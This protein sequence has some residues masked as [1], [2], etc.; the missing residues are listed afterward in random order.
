MTQHPIENRPINSE[1]MSRGTGY[2]TDFIKYIDTLENGFRSEDLDPSMQKMALESTQQFT[3]RSMEEWR[4]Y[5][6]GVIYELKK[7][8]KSTGT[9]SGIDFEEKVDEWNSSY[10]GFQRYLQLIITEGAKIDK[11]EVVMND[12]QIL[13]K[14]QGLG[15]TDNIIHWC[16]QVQIG[17]KKSE[18][19]DI[20][21]IESFNRFREKQNGKITMQHKAVEV[22][23]VSKSYGDKKAVDGVSFTVKRGSIFGLLGPNGAGK[24]T[25]IECIE[26]M[27]E[28]ES[29]KVVLLENERGGKKEIYQKLGIQFQKTGLFENLTIKETLILYA[30]F[31]DKTLSIDEVL[32]L[33]NL[34]K[35]QNKFIKHLSGGMYQSVSLAIAL[36]ND[37]DILFLDEPTTGLDPHVKRDLWGI[38]LK[39]KEQK[40]TVI[41]TTHYMEEAEELCDEI[42]IMD[43]GRVVD[44]GNPAELIKRHLGS[45]TIECRI[46]SEVDMN[47]IENLPGVLRYWKNR[48]SLI[49]LTN[50]ESKT[51]D[52]ILS[53]SSLI[54]KISDLSIRRGN[55]EDVFLKLTDGGLR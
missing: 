31:Y 45:K 38:I 2:F 19:K 21:Q 28:P 32:D 54:D 50:D 7:L 40:K 15:I 46:E 49:I 37:P 42:C 29:G 39:F 8:E 36:L 9:T 33:L 16:S 27:L 3:G 11:R 17:R 14:D 30:S 48:N 25:L 52:A 5:A 55:L 18:N 20:A 43:K 23:A 24:T 6:K 47:S 22:C 12:L 41:I 1:M 13:F 44:L 4:T 10:R 51:V 35:N 26:G 34:K 53:N